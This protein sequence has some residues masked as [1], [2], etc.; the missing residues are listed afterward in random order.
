MESMEFSSNGVRRPVTLLKGLNP[1]MF[2]YDFR[3]FSQNTYL[4]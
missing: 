2:F 1:Q 4:R 3:G